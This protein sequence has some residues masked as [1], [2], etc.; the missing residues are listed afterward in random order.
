MRTSYIQKFKPI[1]IIH[2]TVAIIYFMGV[3]L[4]L[5]HVREVT[6]LMSYKHFSTVT[7]SSLNMNTPSRLICKDGYLLRVKLTLCR[8]AVVALMYMSAQGR[9]SCSGPQT[10]HLEPHHRAFAFH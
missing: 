2:Y 9:Q 8:W 4:Y 6:L 3:F 7:F 10:A 5:K 1:L